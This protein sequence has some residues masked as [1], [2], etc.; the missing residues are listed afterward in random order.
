LHLDGMTFSGSDVLP[1]TLASPQFALN[2]YGSTP[3]ATT[4]DWF[5]A[6][7]GP[8]GVLSQGDAGNLL[9]LQDATMRAQF[10]KTG[11]STYHLRL[12]PNVLPA[13]T[14]DVPQ[15]QGLL[16]QSGRGVVFAGVQ[17]EW[18][19]AVLQHLETSADPT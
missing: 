1:A 2:D 19:R 11:A 4:G 5:T 13:V 16:L 3:Y 10:N 8:G 15:Q 6:P 14:V 9:Q 7:R 12:H 17:F 18:F